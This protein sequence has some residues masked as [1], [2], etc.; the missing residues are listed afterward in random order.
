MWCDLFHG[1]SPQ[2]VSPPHL[3]SVQGSL[4]AVAGALDGG[5]LLLLLAGGL[6]QLLDLGLHIL[7]LPLQLLRLT[8]LS[9][10][11][12][13]E[14]TRDGMSVYCQWGLLS[15]PTWK[16]MLQKTVD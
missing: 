10:A 16:G 15:M 3:E 12:A 7:G 8:T 6:L 14:P 13:A 11:A 4:L 9:T 5:P 2:Q 1:S